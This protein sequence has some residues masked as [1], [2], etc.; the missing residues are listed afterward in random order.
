MENM[1]ISILLLAVAVLI[2]AT[3][4]PEKGSGNE[5]DSRFRD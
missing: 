3:V 5:R 1:W 2:L 4:K